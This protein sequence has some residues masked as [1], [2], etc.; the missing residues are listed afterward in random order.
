LYLLRLE[1]D[2]GVVQ[3]TVIAADAAF[4][5][6]NVTA[7]FLLF[8]AVSKAADAVDNKSEVNPAADTTAVVVVFAVP[9]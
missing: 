7:E 6:C 3:S 2:C 8:F 4:T 1:H 5:I 9:S